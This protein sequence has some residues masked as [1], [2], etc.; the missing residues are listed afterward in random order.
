MKWKKFATVSKVRAKITLSGNK[1][2][3]RDLAN[4]PI[5]STISYI[6]WKNLLHGPRGVWGGA[7][8]KNQ[9]N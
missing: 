9:K 5:G 2:G 8:I 1:Y 3:I 7:K 6:G 4:F